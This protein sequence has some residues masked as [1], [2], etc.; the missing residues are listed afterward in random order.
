MPQTTY[1][2]NILR[3]TRYELEA[4]FSD[5]IRAEKYIAKR[6]KRCLEQNVSLPDY[7]VL[8]CEEVLD[9]GNAFSSMSITANHTVSIALSDFVAPAAK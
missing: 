5:Q 3:G 1:V 6:Y 2:I 9:E 4:A 7:Q 8:K